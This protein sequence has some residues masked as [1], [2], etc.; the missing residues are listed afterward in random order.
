MTISNQVFLQVAPSILVLF[1]CRYLLPTLDY[2][3]SISLPCSAY[4]ALEKSGSEEI[5]GAL[6]SFANSAKQADYQGRNGMNATP[7]APNAMGRGTPAVRP[8]P[9]PLAA[10]PPARAGRGLIP[11]R[12]GFTPGG[13]FFFIQT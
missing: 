10:Y 9:G 1:T 8:G 5:G 11:A 3:D 12:G 7:R 6:V 4:R 13:I 2:A